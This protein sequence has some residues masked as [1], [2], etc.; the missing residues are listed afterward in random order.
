MPETFYVDGDPFVVTDGG[1][2]AF[3]VIGDTMDAAEIEQ[4]IRR[5]IREI[6]PVRVGPDDI[7]QAIAD[8]VNLLGLV[9][10]GAN[11]TYFNVRKSLSSFTHIFALPSGAHEV[12]DVKDMGDNAL[13]VIG[14]A[15]NGSGLIQ[16]T[17]DGVHGW[18]TG[19]II[20]HHDIGGTTEANDTFAITVVDTTNY[21]L[22]GSTFAN[23]YASGGKAF[24][25]TEDFTKIVRKPMGELNNFT[26]KYYTRGNNVVIDDTDFENDIIIEY[27]DLP[28]EVSDIPGRYHYGIVNFG[29]I[30][31]IVLP[32]F[33]TKH[34]PDKAAIRKFHEGLWNFCLQSA[35]G[36][37]TSSESNNISDVKRVK[38]WV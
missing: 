22:D 23:A 37:K 27:H 18:E 26:E 15:N 38:R 3:K 4:F 28:S 19:Y 35:R 30:S 24:R 7:A 8:A 10:V 9:L 33:N 31:L 29:V 20:T 21:T 34:Y 36:F 32:Q 6:G 17:T 13:S 1:G 25:E 11:P 12:S 5:D 2:E 14:A 16:I